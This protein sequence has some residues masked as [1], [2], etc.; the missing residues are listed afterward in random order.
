M[1]PDPADW[2]TQASK[3]RY[4]HTQWPEPPESAPAMVVWVLREH[5]RPKPVLAKVV[6]K[7][8]AWVQT[9]DGERFK[10]FSTAFFTELAAWCR[11]QGKLD[12]IRKTA[13]KSSPQF[14]GLA[15]QLE[16]GADN[17]RGVR[18]EVHVYLQTQQYLWWRERY[19]LRH[20]PITS[21]RPRHAV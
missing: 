9:P 19:K 21:T 15:L 12:L 20:A 5:R 2:L 3:Y 13:H 11:W 18:A 1:M 6:G 7:N 17:P 10:L 14:Q 4:L 8:K 16:F